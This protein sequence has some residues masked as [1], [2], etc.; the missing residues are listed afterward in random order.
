MN[1]ELVVNKTYK[2]KNG[3][4]V[5]ILTDRYMT[6]G[7]EFCCL[8]QYKQGQAYFTHCFHKNGESLLGP[9]YNIDFTTK[10]KI[11][12]VP[13]YVKDYFDGSW[14]LGFKTFRD[15]ESAE[16]FTKNRI[17]VSMY[18]VGTIQEIEIKVDA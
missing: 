10:V 15:M 18:K 17:D 13:Y 14:K 16:S 3:H 6:S 4:E 12:I 11:Y 8:G 1:N 7:H 2:M 9:E 5:T